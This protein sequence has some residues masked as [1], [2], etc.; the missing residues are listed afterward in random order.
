[1]GIDFDTAIG[2]PF[3]TLVKRFRRERVAA[4]SG[5]GDPAARRTGGDCAVFSRD[6]DSKDLGI[7]GKTGFKHA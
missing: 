7:F 5:C 4:G 3:A 2:V 1:M 6:T